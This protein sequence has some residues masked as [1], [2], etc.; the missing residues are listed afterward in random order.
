MV[1][2]RTMVVLCRTM[3]GVH[4]VSCGLLVQTFMANTRELV[5]A[6]TLMIVASP[7]GLRQAVLHLPTREHGMVA[8]LHHSV[9]G[10][11]GPL[12]LPSLLMV[13]HDL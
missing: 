10:R 12:L 9:K 8:L 13:M 2:Y 7:N 4:E 11:T 5:L 3:V 1:P 6:V